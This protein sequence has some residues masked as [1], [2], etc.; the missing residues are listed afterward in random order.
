MTIRSFRDLDVYQ[1]SLTLAKEIHFL[2]KDFPQSE[3]FLL[4][5]QMK[6]ASRAVPS[7]I[8]EGWAK[9]RQ[10]KEFKKYIRN[11]IGEANEMMSHIEQSRMFSYIK[12]K[13][14]NELIERYDQLA[15]KLHSLKDK[16][17]NY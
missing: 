1:E 6:R 9:R 10:T 4:V 3:K 17:Q 5:D 13:K 2:L 14:A 7:L 16:W 15:E 8:A 11:V 12:E